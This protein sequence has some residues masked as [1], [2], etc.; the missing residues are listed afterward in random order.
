M[1]GYK[2]NTELMSFLYLFSQP[3]LCPLSTRGPL[4]PF[5]SRETRNLRLAQTA[6]ILSMQERKR[7]SKMTA[8]LRFQ[9]LSR[10]TSC[11]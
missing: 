1:I 8:Q 5:L 6:G 3:A 9:E 4:L 2:L 10:D 11:P 7:R